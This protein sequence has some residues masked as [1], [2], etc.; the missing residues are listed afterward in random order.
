MTKHESFTFDSVS[1][2][3]IFLGHGA[4]VCSLACKLCILAAFTKNIVQIF[5]KYLKVF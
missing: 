5:P 3:C 4:Q 1:M 2:G